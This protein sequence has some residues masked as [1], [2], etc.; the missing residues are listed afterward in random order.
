MPSMLPIALGPVV[1]HGIHRNGTEVHVRSSRVVD[2]GTVGEV[3]ARILAC[4]G[5]SKLPRVPHESAVRHIHGAATKKK[6]AS[7]SHCHRGSV[8]IRVAKR[9]I[10]VDCHT[11]EMSFVAIKEKGATVTPS[12]VFRDDVFHVQ[13]AGVTELDQCSASTVQRPVDPNHGEFRDHIVVQCHM[14]HLNIVG[15]GHCTRGKTKSSSLG[16]GSVVPE[17]AVIYVQSRSETG[18]FVRNLVQPEATS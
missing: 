4:N 16:D 7:S 6:C 18:S 1:V 2:E 13:D 10:V 5:S 15:L 8:L 17:H 12:V 9:E 3:D 14:V 11:I